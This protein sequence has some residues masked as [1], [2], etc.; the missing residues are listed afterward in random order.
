MA[1]TVILP[2][3]TSA[4]PSAWR[5]VADNKSETIMLTST[6]SLGG[7]I[8]IEVKSGAGADDATQIGTMQVL[9]QH[10]VVNGE[11]GKRISGPTTYR[12]RRIGSD[13]AGVSVES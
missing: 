13:L 5:T 3:G 10:E 2:D 8:S 1:L 11:R 9:L 7:K 12:V 6:T 4:T